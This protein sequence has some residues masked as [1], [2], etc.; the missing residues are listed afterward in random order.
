MLSA[1][2][3][4][5]L[6]VAAD[7]ERARR[8]LEEGEERELHG[9]ALPAAATHAVCGASPASAP[10]RERV[11]LA[12]ATRCDCNRLRR[13]PW[14]GTDRLWSRRPR[15]AREALAGRYSAWRLPMCR[16]NQR[17]RL[18]RATRSAVPARGREGPSERLGAEDEREL[19]ERMQL[20]NP[21][22]G[23]RFLVRPRREE[24][25]R[26]AEVHAMA[27]GLPHPLRERGVGVGR[28]GLARRT[29]TRCDRRCPRCAR[30]S[31]S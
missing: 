19:E 27:E 23:S 15:S 25:P 2:E 3:A 4:E 22:P 14:P 11:E 21:P 18:R 28:E 1:G 13:R 24:E 31:P 17:A 10:P 16:A 29:G 8:Q 7:G 12:F 6:R 26:V 20:Q 9:G 30:P 5:G